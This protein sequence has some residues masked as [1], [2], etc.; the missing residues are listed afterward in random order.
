[1]NH[2]P[3]TIKLMQDSGTIDMSDGMRL[4]ML[5]MEVVNNKH[6]VESIKKTAGYLSTV[7]DISISDKY[8]QEIIESHGAK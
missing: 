6:T 1:M 8:L 5:A 7:N 3:L 2:Y 4:E